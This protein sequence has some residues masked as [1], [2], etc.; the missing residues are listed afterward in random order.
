MEDMKLNELTIANIL[1]EMLL[2]GAD[3][4]KLELKLPDGT[5][6]VMRIEVEILEDD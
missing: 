4:S 5:V 2:R 1:S 3:K 6:V